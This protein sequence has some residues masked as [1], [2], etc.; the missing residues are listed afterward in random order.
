M[1][2]IGEGI[3]RAPEMLEKMIYTTESVLTVE[4]CLP[5]RRQD[6]RQMLYQPF[7]P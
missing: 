6:Y 4:E 7:L 1:I 2:N 5:F 3:Q